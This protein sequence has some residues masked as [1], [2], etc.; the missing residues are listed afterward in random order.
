MFEPCAKVKAL[1]LDKKPAIA[2]N[3][4]IRKSRRKEAGPVVTKLFSCSIQLSMKFK[5]VINIKMAKING[6]FRFKPSKPVIYPAN[7]C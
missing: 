6:I 1:A 4:E 3:K 5:I 2:M 7:K